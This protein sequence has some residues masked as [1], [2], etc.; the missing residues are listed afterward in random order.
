MWLNDVQD[1]VRLPKSI[2]L[3]PFVALNVARLLKS[4]HYAQIVIEDKKGRHCLAT[5]VHKKED[6]NAVPNFESPTAPSDLYPDLSD[7]A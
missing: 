7:V 3:N 2:L 1:E 4:A 5:R 6:T